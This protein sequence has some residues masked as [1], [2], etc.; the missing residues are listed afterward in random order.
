MKQLNFQ[1]ELHFDFYIQKLPLLPLFVQGVLLPGIF[2]EAPQTGTQF[3]RIKHVG[4]T[5][6]FQDLV[7]TLKIDEGMESWFEM[8]KWITGIGRSESF[9]QFSELVSNSVKSLDGLSRIFKDEHPSVDKSK[10]RNLKSTGSLTISD[11]NYV[12]YMEIVFM[13]MHPTSISGL[14]FRTDETS[15]AFITFDVTFAYNYYYPRLIR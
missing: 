7:V 14:T 10:Y 2:T 6:F 13:D 9:A 1:S 15:V 11:A 12:K 5:V 3:S 8:Y 4:D